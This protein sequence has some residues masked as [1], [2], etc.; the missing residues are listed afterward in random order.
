MKRILFTIAAG[1]LAYQSYTFL[2]HLEEL[3]FE[4]IFGNIFLAWVLNMFIT[5]VFAFLVFAWPASRIL[6]E[7][8]Y[9]I[10]NPNRLNRI[11]QVT[12]GELYRK[13]LLMTLW[14]NKEQQKRYFNGKKEGLRHLDFQ[15]RQSEWGHM[16]PFV[17]LLITSILLF[18]EKIY[19]LGGWVL[20]FNVLGNFYPVLL[21]RHHRMRIQRLLSLKRG[22]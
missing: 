6:P 11:F 5:G 15:S 7:S 22:G 3:Q 12:G 18:K 19:L 8:Y 20:I 16:I 21:Q 13:F 1:F 4:S 2:T 17:I 10:Q 9:I 14:R